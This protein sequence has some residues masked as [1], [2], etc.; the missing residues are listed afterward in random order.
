MS[1]SCRVQSMQATIDIGG[2][3]QKI[4]EIEDIQ[5][6]EEEGGG[7][8][9]IFKD[10]II[11]ETDLMD[12]TAG[13]INARDD[14]DD[15]AVTRRGKL[16]RKKSKSNVQMITFQPNTEPETQVAQIDDLDLQDSPN[17]SSRPSLVPESVAS[18]A[19]T[20]IIR[21]TD[22]FGEKSVSYT[23]DSLKTLRMGLNFDI[24]ECVFNRYV[25]FMFNLFTMS[26]ISKKSW[27]FFEFRTLKKT[28]KFS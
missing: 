23:D 26:T 11:N 15:E 1:S 14:E 19:I 16:R 4:D 5:E 2:M 21:K 3:A 18:T 24:V 10:G 13:C 20:K 8:D 6:L 17:M 22:D 9:E 7:G 27:H 28:L 12:P 25:R